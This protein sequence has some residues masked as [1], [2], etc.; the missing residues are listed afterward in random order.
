ME[1]IELYFD[2]FQKLVYKSNLI[3]D[4]NGY[5]I[6][7]SKAGTQN[8]LKGVLNMIKNWKDYVVE[9]ADIESL[10]ADLRNEGWLDDEGL[11]IMVDGSTK[12]FWNRYDVVFKDEIL[13]NS[14]N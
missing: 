5:N 13:L 9:G 3:C 11:D 12:Q 10:E 14:N 4:N 6:Y 1:L 7:S 8:K 2:I